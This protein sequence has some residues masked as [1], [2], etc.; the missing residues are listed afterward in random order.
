M[1]IHINSSAVTIFIVYSYLRSSTVTIIDLFI[2]ITVLLSL[3]SP[4]ND[5]TIDYSC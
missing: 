1:F 5:S 3:F 2:I 4:Y